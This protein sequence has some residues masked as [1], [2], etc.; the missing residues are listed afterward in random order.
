MKGAERGAM[1]FISNHHRGGADFQAE[2]K[3]RIRKTEELLLNAPKNF[4]AIATLYGR[5][6]PSEISIAVGRICS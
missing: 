2:T 3:R 5:A 4:S 6:Y 1:N